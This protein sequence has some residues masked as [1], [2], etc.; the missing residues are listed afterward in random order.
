MIKIIETNIS[1][2]SNGELADHQSRII[3]VNSWDQY[4]NDL[5]ECKPVHYEGTLI[6][7]TVPRQS[8]VENLKYDDSHAS[9]IVEIYSGAKT[10]KLAYKVNN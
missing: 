1:L 5:K 9:C 7:Y 3:E 10:V 6:G 8:K 2:T 4:I